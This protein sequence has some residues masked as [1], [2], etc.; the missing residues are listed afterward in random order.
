[1]ALSAR[2]L[3]QLRSRTRLSD[4]EGIE[5]ALTAIVAG[6]PVWAA[7]SAPGVER[8]VLPREGAALAAVEAI[9]RAW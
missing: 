8:L 3:D 7:L 5:T 2:F 9:A 6:V 4:A 1:M